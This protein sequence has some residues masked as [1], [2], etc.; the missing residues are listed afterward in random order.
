MLQILL[1]IG[2]LLVPAARAE[3]PVTAFLFRGT[4]RAQIAFIGAERRVEFEALVKARRITDPDQ[5]IEFL[6]RLTRVELLRVQAHNA[7]LETGVAYSLLQA[8][9]AGVTHFG[10]EL[11]LGRILETP[12]SLDLPLTALRQLFAAKPPQEENDLDDIARLFTLRAGMLRRRWTLSVGFL[13]LPFEHA[14]TSAEVKDDRDSLNADLERFFGENNKYS[15]DQGNYLAP[16]FR[17]GGERDREVYLRLVERLLHSE[18]V[19]RELKDELSREIDFEKRYGFPQHP[20]AVAFARQ[21][22][23]YLGVY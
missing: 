16:A 7:Q 22:I 2:L 1:S 20:F 13:E 15:Y 17:L 21:I 3:L 5:R 4:C 8:Y 12:G 9:Q 19:P 6:N 18:K 23:A 11:V 10:H 14:V